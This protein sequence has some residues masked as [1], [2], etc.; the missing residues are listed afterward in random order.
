MTALIPR[1][2]A[3]LL[4]LALGGCALQAQW[5]HLRDM[6][7]RSREEV[8]ALHAAQARATDAEAARSAREA[9]QDV[10]KP[11]LAGP[12]QAL[13]REVALPAPLRARVDTTLIFAGRAG[14][15]VIAERLQR[16]TGIAVRVLPE[17]LLPAELF[18]PRLAEKAALA[19]PAL[20]EV[21]LHEGPRPLADI[22]DTLAARLLVWWR[23]HDG[24]IEFYRSQTRAFDLRML[25]LEARSQAQLGRRADEAEGFDNAIQASVTVHLPT[26][27]QRVRTQIE[28]FLSRAG[29]AV[30]ADEGGTLVVTDTPAVLARVEA[31]IA[32]QNTRASRRVRLLFEEITLVMHNSAEGAIDWRL[33]H[34]S[35]RAALEGVFPAAARTLAPG[36]SAKAPQGAWG[37]SKALLSALA[38]FGAI[39]HHRSIPLLTLNRR[40]VT[41]AVHS[42]FSYVDQVQGLQT[43]T[44]STELPA[45]SVN[46]KR[47][48]VGT[49][50]TLLPDAQDDG[51]I[52]LS[53]G[54]DNTAAQPL[55]TLAFGDDSRP[56]QVQQL[57]LDGN[58]SVQQVRV[59]PGHPVLLS[60]FDR[61]VDSF[62]RQRLTPDAPLLAGGRDQ[63]RQE[64]LLTVIV[65]SAQLEEADG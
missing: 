30:L 54:Y 44:G 45:L 62:D 6:L 29:V 12:A 15:T 2:P 21:E 10:G 24:A 61:S 50:L 41:Y 43:G 26:P 64:R 37:G 25:P 51:S 33:L 40:P 57:N 14:L 18:L 11:W 17:A 42:T 46:Q 47:V 13:A 52:L 65:L 34:A 35:A 19:I 56:L 63:A 20:A 9:A 4:C 5:Q 55:K 60:G 27:A 58:G 22:L 23:Y 28:P 16:A 49:F 48:T 31:F 1:L 39:R 53:I 38:Q 8:E 59:R 36:L 32:Q 7:G 3:L